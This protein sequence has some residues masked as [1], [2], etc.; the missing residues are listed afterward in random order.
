MNKKTKYNK[1]KKNK[2][3]TKKYYGGNSKEEFEK[4]KVI[5]DVII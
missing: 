3:K 4:S 2:N 5:F 1:R